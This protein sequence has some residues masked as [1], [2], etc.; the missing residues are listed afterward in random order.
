LRDAPIHVD[1]LAHRLPSGKLV[2]GD[3]SRAHRLPQLISIP[4]YLILLIGAI[5]SAWTMRGRPELKERFVGTVL[6]VIGASVVAG[7]ATFAAYGN[8]PGFCITLVVGIIA[9]FVGFL[10]ASR[11]MRPAAIADATVSSA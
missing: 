9:M 4:S 7:G 1:A 10:R 6:I 5:W 3:G 2:F 8:L 11:P